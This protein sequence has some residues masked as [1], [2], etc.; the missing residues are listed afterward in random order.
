MGLS[1]NYVQRT[2]ERETGTAIVTL[3]V[4]RHAT[5]VIPRPAAF[6]SLE[7]KDD[8]L[9]QLGELEADWLYFGTLSQMNEANLQLLEKMF[10]LMPRIRGFYD[11]NLREGHWNLPL[12]EH[13]ASLATVVKLND[14]EAEILFG[15]LFPTETFS[16]ENFCLAWSA[17]F[18]LSLLC[19]TLGDRGCAVFRDGKLQEFAGIPVHVADTVGAGDAFA[20]G[21]LHAISQPWSLELQATFAN[22]LGALVASLPGAT[23]DWT[24]ADCE[25]LIATSYPTVDFLARSE[26]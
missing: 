20:A 17:R 26:A 19:V 5:F 22:G 2:V 14:V 6:D 3:D 8:L 10:K 21:L 1:T 23:P 12:V 24:L 4:N 7:M 9:T 16:L 15:L 11:I 13:L 18:R 25:R